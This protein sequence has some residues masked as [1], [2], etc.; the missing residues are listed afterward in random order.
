VEAKASGSAWNQWEEYRWAGGS[1]AH[2]G[3]RKRTLEGT[4]CGVIQYS[5]GGY[6]GKWLGLNEPSEWPLL[7]TE[8]F[9][10]STRWGKVSRKEVGERNIPQDSRPWMLPLSQAIPQ[11]A[12]LRAAPGLP[13]CSLLSGKVLIMSRMASGYLRTPHLPLALPFTSYFFLVAREAL[14]SSRNLLLPFLGPILQGRVNAESLPE[15]E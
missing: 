10:A 3:G 7:R 4:K 2:M 5:G 11:K 15:K 6:Q 8:S 12:R 14:G 1:G 13:H 9:V